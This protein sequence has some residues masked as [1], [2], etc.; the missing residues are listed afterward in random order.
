MDVDTLKD[1]YIEQ[2]RDL[3][4]AEQQSAAAAKEMAAAA[5][6]DELKTALSEHQT[7]CEQRLARIEQ[8][9]SGLGE[10]ATGH[11]CKGMEGLV[12]EAKGAIDEAGNDDV[13]DAALITHTQRMLHY[14]LAGFGTVNTYAGRLDKEAQ[15]FF[16]QVLDQTYEADRALTDLATARVNPDA[17]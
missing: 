12:K 13:R 2:L 15:A 4:S 16:K 1:L 6:H 8:I 5:A 7:R 17:A 10:K 3:Y 14:E 9:V 11:K